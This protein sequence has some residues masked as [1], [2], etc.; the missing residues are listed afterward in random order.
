MKPLFHAI[1][2]AYLGTPLWA[3]SCAGSIT[4]C[5]AMTKSDVAFVGTV[6]TGT[7]PSDRSVH[8]GFGSTPALVKVQTVVRGLDDGVSEI[9]VNPSVGTS[10]YFAMKPGERWLVFGRHFGEFVMTS[11]CSGSHVVAA[12]DTITDR[13]IGSFLKGPNL[14]TGEVRT[15]T[16]WDSPWRKDN[17]INDVQ[18]TLTHEGKKWSTTS[19]VSGRFELR[20]LPAGDYDMAVRAPGMSFQQPGDDAL[21]P[22]RSGVSPKLN[23]P[24]SGC[25]EAPLMMWPDQA[26]KGRVTGRDGNPISHLK[27]GAYKLNEQGQPA[28]T[29]LRATLTDEGGG[30]VLPRLPNGSYVV[31]VNADFG[32]D[33]SPYRA[34]FYPSADS[35]LGAMT[36]TLDGKTYDHVDI[37]M[38]APRKLVDVSVKVR[39]EDGTPASSALILVE[40]D[41]KGIIFGDPRDLASHF[42][43][44][45][46][47]LNVKLFDGDQYLLAAQ[48]T[49][50]QPGSP[51]RTKAVAESDKVRVVGGA[52]T[53]VTITLKKPQPIP[54]APALPH[55]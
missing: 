45:A 11:G 25:V 50:F 8:G 14:F 48:W 32:V 39:F 20:D 16:G 27:I 17:L 6:I 54:T 29:S 38:D 19:D 4:T 26:I 49:E 1:M 3:C 21:F 53:M 12:S 55:K 24:A 15:Y 36:V 22:V 35:V 37:S 31:G 30:Y 34:R 44:G 10:C 13:M 46:G 9:K 2:L 43:N 40:R 42:T 33:D 23:M 51:L 5:E 52:G 7:E 41:D 47:V 18:I 28:R